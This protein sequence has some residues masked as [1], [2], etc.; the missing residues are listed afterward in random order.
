VG[1]R[2]NL[3]RVFI[4]NDRDVLQVISTDGDHR[5]ETNAEGCFNLAS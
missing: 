1:T 3:V 4:F 2:G 5:T